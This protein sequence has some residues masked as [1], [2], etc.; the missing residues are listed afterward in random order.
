MIPEVQV[1]ILDVG[2]ESVLADVAP[3]VFD[4]EVQ[5]S[6]L[7][8]F[9][10]DPRHHLAVAIDQ[11]TVVGVASAVHYVHPDKPPELWVNEIGVAPTHQSRGLGRRLVA[12]LFTVGRSLGCAEAWVLAEDENQRARGFYAALGGHA[13]SCTM[14]SFDLGSAEPPRDP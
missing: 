8:E 6:L 4:R 10:G 12:A 11:G 14:Y 9:L 1:R 7:A 5:P 3:G 13:T 2:E